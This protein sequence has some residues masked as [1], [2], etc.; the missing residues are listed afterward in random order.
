MNAVSMLAGKEYQE[1]AWLSYCLKNFC[2]TR[3]GGGPIILCI[4]LIW[5]SSLEPGNKGRRVRL[6]I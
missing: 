2:K 5:S 3:V 4:L 6:G 1:E